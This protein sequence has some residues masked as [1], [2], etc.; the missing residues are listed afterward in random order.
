VMCESVNPTP[1]SK[2]SWG[3]LKSRFR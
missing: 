1:V 3:S 2:T